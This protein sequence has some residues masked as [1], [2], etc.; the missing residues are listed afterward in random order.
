M[1]KKQLGCMGV[2][3]SSKI[4]VSKS[5]VNPCVKHRNMAIF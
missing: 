3:A 4:V 1:L 5:Y 2:G